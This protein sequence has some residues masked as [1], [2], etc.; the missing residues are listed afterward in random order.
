[1]LS[2]DPHI[3]VCG[4]WWVVCNRGDGGLAPVIYQVSKTSEASG[5]I[6][7]GTQ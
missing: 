7:S 5:D 4:G 2:K 3:R 6:P 1:V